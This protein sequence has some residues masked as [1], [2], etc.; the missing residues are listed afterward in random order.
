MIEQGGIENVRRYAGKKIAVTLSADDYKDV[1]AAALVN[2]KALTTFNVADYMLQDDENN[3]DYMVALVRF[4]GKGV[5]DV[6]YG[7]NKRVLVN[8]ALA[9]I[10]KEIN[11]LQKKQNSKI[12]IVAEKEQIADNIEQ[13]VVKKLK[14]EIEA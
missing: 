2:S 6:L 9:V 12:D 1:A 7:S 11:E 5:G 3:T 8:T 4:D 13:F 14:N 10:G